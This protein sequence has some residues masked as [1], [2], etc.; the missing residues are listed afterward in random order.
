MLKPV[1]LFYPTFMLK[2]L[3]YTTN[4]YMYVCILIVHFRYMKIFDT[5]PLKMPHAMFSYA[6]L[7]SLSLSLS[8][9]LSLSLTHTHTRDS[10][11]SFFRVK[12][13]TAV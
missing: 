9:S 1:S 7:L 3:L 11:R 10:Y 5:Q 2:T 8:H 6:F 4:M 13:S 12:D